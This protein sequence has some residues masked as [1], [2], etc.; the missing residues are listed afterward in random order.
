MEDLISRGAA[1]NALGDPPENWT[2]ADGELSECAAYEE[3][4]VALEAL[5]SVKE[6]PWADEI[7]AEKE[8][9]KW[10]K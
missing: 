9:S 10:W 5:P 1:I 8:R 2:G 3:H 4:G 6:M 7:A